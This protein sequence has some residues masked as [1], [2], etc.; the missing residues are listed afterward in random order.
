MKLHKHEHKQKQTRGR[1]TRYRGIYIHDGR[2]SIR[3]RGRCPKTGKEVERER[4]TLR[5]T[6]IR[7]ALL[8]QQRL[9]EELR[10]EAQQPR[11]RMTVGDYA[12]CW[13]EHLSVTKRV[14]DDTT[15]RGRV[16]ALDLHIL[17]SIGSIFIEELTLK[18]LKDWQ[19]KM[20][21]K[22]QVTRQGKKAKP[23]SAA[24]INNWSRIV[25]TMLRDAVSDLALSRDPTLGFRRLPEDPK[26]KSSLTQD[27]LVRW[28]LAAQ[29]L[30]PDHFAMVVFLMTSGL[31]FGEASAIHWD[32][33]DERE[34]LVH[35]Q[36]RQVRGRLAPVKTRKSRSV[37][38]D[39]WVFEVLREH[40]RGLMRDQAPGWDKGIV[41]PSHTGSYR[42][43]SVLNKPFTK[44]AA[45]TEIDKH[46]T[47][48]TLRRTFN[49]LMR[50]SGVDRMTL[51]AMTGHS[52]EE[53]TQH[54][55]D[56]TPEEKRQAVARGLSPLLAL[57]REQTGD[58]TGDRSAEQGKAHSA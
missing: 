5:G 6:T 24:T 4:L 45:V 15:L 53:M 23:Y 49:N 18:D 25:K 55:S 7:Q 56:V 9:Q 30:Y 52:S 8:E 38:L 14:R 44:I 37:A 29:Q 17:P 3:V 31:R 46:V 43:P 50:Q 39:P 10:Q 22:R 36:R 34:Q 47:A 12:H 13:I 42:H 20:T 48:H 32:N 1:A 19:A 35:V 41:F 2:Y 21:Q 11:P 51:R 27:E 16:E 58:E 40:R 57:V 54:Y 33:I 26:P 28:L